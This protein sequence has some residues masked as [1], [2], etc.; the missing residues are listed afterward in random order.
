MYVV[1]S[2]ATVHFFIEFG[3]LVP[4]PRPSLKAL[5]MLRAKSLIIVSE[6]LCGDEAGIF[7][8]VLLLASSMDTRT[9]SSPATAT[10]VINIRSEWNGLSVS[11][12]FPR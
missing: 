3:S 2:H 1:K 12:P 4:G 11:V 7:V 10:G 6:F 5:L 8:D 9:E